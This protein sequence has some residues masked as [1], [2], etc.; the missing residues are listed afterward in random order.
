VL[1]HQVAEVFVVANGMRACRTRPL[2]APP[3]RTPQIGASLT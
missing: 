2:A 3:G 1:V